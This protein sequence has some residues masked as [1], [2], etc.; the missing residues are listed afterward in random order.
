MKATSKRLARVGD[1]ICCDQKIEGELARALDGVARHDE[2]QLSRLY[3][4]TRERVYS[5]AVFMTRDTDLAEDVVVEVYSQVWLQADRFQ[6]SRGTVMNW[7]LMITR[8][9]SLDLIRA[10][11]RFQ[12]RETLL[13]HAH[14]LCQ[15]IDEDPEELHMERDQAQAVR[16][17]MR[18][19]P[20]EQRELLLA[21]Y[22]VGMTH[23][24]LAE[25]FDLPLGTVKSRIRLGLQSLKREL[26]QLERSWS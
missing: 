22:F 25:H 10:R 23:V 1:S 20:Q 9:R 3:D 17:S 18:A 2:Y 12:G 26:T 8:C 5:L 7:L 16:K 19:L 24:E 11:Q 13:E 15:P 6:P 14:M 4:L 21:G